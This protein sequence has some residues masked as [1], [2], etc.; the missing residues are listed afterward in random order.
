MFRTAAFFSERL[1][2]VAASAMLFLTSSAFG[3]TD[4]SGNWVLDL[5]SSSSPDA[6]LKRL[7]AS[8]VE[9]QFGGKL[10][11]EA[12]YTQTPKSLT[13]QLR[14]IGF[15]RT[16]VL[17]INNQ[18]QTVQDPILGKYTI[19]TFWSGDGTQLLSVVAL[20]TKDA[21]DAQLMIVRQLSDGGKTLALSG[22]LKVTGESGSWTLRRVWRKRA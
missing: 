16:D 2:L 6:M 21:K 9:R 1:L 12:T 4:F 11:L 8:W 18:P 10:Q 22:T 17:P 7:G 20:R 13:V 19:R 15:Q 3:V 14:G 5:R